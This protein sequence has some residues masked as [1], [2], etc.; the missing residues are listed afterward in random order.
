M[1]RLFQYR[2]TEGQ[3][4]EGH[5]FGNLFIAAMTAIT[6]NFE[7]GLRESS[8]VLAVRGQIVPSTLENLTLCAEFDDQATAIGESAIPKAQKGIKRVFFKPAHP[9]AYPDAIR[10]ILEADLIVIGPGSLYTSV[11]PNLLVEDI[12][13][14]IRSSRATKVFVCNVATEQGETDGFSATDFLQAFE[15]HV[16]PS[17]VQYVLINN[18]TDIGRASRNA[19]HLVTSPD[20]L[21]DIGYT[22]VTSDV[23]DSVEPRRHHPKKLAQSILRIYYD[24]DHAAHGVAVDADPAKSFAQV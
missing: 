15:R 6:G 3:G 17:L 16:G 7:R 5:S 24:R 9:A 10:A 23:I 12:G 4:L 14:S 13:R 11:L 20:G 2:F 21:S 18:N 19:P 22:V 8:R 1:T